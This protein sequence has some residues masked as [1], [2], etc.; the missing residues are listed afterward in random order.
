MKAYIQNNWTNTSQNYQTAPALAFY[1]SGAVPTDRASLLAALP[2]VDVPTLLEKCV[3]VGLMLCTR[4]KD[5]NLKVRGQYKAFSDKLSMLKRG[6][7]PFKVNSTTYNYPMPSKAYREDGKSGL[8]WMPPTLF[9]FPIASTNVYGATINPVIRKPNVRVKESETDVGAEASYVIEYA[10][11]TTISALFTGACEARGGIEPTSV[12]V[13]YWTGAAWATAMSGQYTQDTAKTFTAVTSTKFR[14][15]LGLSQSATS[16]VTRLGG[17]AL[18]HTAAKSPITLSDS[19][20]WVAILP[21]PDIE[22]SM[23]NP[24][25]LNDRLLPYTEAEIRLNSTV[26]EAGAM[27]LLSSMAPI[28]IDTC[29]T[30]PVSA[31]AL[32][33]KSTGLIATTDR[34]AVTL[35]DYILG[36]L[37]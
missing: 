30:S 3:G 7:A 5:A 25:Y 22:L 29:G 8:W 2:A 34:P 6:S 32:I 15:V 31:K 12:R 35:Y 26:C 20:S 36:D 14:I 21:M 17:L 27:D 18:L 37:G 19:I 4:Y 24:L 16:V 33:S 28:V 9:A 13:D 10:D 23:S 11:S 1:M